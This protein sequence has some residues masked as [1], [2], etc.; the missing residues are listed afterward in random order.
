[1]YEFADVKT[2]SLICCRPAI[3]LLISCSGK[4][5]PMNKREAIY[6]MTDR[7]TTGLIM[8]ERLIKRETVT[9]NHWETRR[10]Y[11]NLPVI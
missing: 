9:E 5:S 1:L 4:I 11:P 7:D 3:L 8:A 6:R 10:F 2:N